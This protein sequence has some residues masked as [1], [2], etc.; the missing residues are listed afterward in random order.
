MAATIFGLADIRRKKGISARKLAEALGWTTRRVQRYTCQPREAYLSAVESNRS[1]ARRMHSEGKR[2]AQIAKEMGVNRSTV[3]RW[4]SGI[5]VQSTELDLP[6]GE[7]QAR[8]EGDWEQP[9]VFG[10]N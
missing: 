2:P 1:T 4:L 5:K 3:G 6:L 9:P 10:V 8:T 7:T